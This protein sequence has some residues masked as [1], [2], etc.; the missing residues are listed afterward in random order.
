MAEIKDLWIT[1][2]RQVRASV[3]G[4]P[5]WRTP[6]GRN[7]ITPRLIRV[8]Y[9]IDTGEI[10]GIEVLGERVN[11]KPTPYRSWKRNLT[12]RLFGENGLAGA[13]E[14]VRDFVEQHR[15]LPMGE[16]FENPLI[17]LPHDVL[18]AAARQIHTGYDRAAP[19]ERSDAREVARD[20]L[21]AAAAVFQHPRKGG[22]PWTS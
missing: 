20:A 1:N 2:D 6:G 13:P 10:G 4:A 3:S 21:L 14:W 15:P 22:A 9:S 12:R 7:P 5:E 16:V 8:R 19:V 18:E 11:D 17:D